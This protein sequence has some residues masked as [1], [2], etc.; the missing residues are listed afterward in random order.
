M[1]SSMQFVHVGNHHF[2][3]N[4]V[5]GDIINVVD[6]HIITEIA[7]DDGTIVQT[8]RHDN[9]VVFQRNA[10]QFA[11]THQ[12][13]KLAVFHQLR[14]LPANDHLSPFTLCSPL[15]T[16]HDYGHLRRHRFGSVLQ[17]EDYPV[18]NKA[19]IPYTMRV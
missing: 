9:V 16:V 11:Y 2:V 7:T 13:K 6:D 3:A 10:F 18:T 8:D 19:A 5:M 12:S 1:I 17:P 15:P 4:Y 14:T